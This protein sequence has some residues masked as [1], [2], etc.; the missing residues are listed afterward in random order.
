MYKNSK[1]KVKLLA[2][3]KDLVAKQMSGKADEFLPLHMADMESIVFVNEGE[4]ELHIDG[5]KIHLKEFDAYIV[6]ADL[7]HQ[8]LG[9]TDFK[10]VHFMPK[11]IKID[12]I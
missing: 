1:P 4:C 9:I 5:E 3:G 6:P 7:K 11:N 2:S 10:A 12:F 8:F